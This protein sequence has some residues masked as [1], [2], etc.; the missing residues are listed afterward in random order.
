M[1]CATG[2]RTLFQ[3]TLALTLSLCFLFLLC[4]CS[5]QAEKMLT[6][7]CPHLCWYYRERKR[8]EE[9]DLPNMF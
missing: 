4:Y 8:V 7:D 9:S 5:E 1:Q 2:H 6:K 3:L